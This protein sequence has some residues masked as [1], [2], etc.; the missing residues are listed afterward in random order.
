MIRRF[1]GNAFFFGAPAFLIVIACTVFSLRW[2][3][4]PID[5]KNVDRGRLVRLLQFRDF[6]PLPPPLVAN[7]SERYDAEFGRRSEKM[8]E[9]NFSTAEKRIYTHYGGTRKST[10]TRF[11]TNLNL[12]ARAKYFDWM[13]RFES[14]PRKEHPALMLEIIDDMKWW[15]ELYMNFLRAAGLPIPSLAELMEEFDGMIESFKDGAADADIAR[16]DRFKRQMVVGFAAHELR[17]TFWP[18]QRVAEES[19]PPP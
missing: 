17:K 16:I 11:E 10:S 9:F 19:D 3:F 6:R 1:F 15:E 4:E 18:F 8:P 13:A 2:L 14:L 7:L 5:P 12:L